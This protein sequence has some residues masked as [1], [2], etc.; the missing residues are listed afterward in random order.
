M[1]ILAYQRRYIAFSYAVLSMFFHLFLSMSPLV[2]ISS[3]VFSIPPQLLLLFGLYLFRDIHGRTAVQLMNGVPPDSGSFSS[4]GIAM[5]NTT[6]DEK[7]RALHLEK[8][9]YNE[10]RYE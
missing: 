8:V 6:R 2:L 9:F 5:T 1:F 4:S 3:Q 7:I 10:L